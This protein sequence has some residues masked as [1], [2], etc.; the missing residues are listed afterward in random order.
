MSQREGQKVHAPAIFRSAAAWRDAWQ[1]D[2]VSLRGWSSRH[3]KRASG[4]NTKEAR[5][6]ADTSVSVGA[7]S[8]DAHSSLLAATAVLFHREAV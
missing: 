2:Q 3:P 4:V 1:A 5:E 7:L 8:Y 6:G